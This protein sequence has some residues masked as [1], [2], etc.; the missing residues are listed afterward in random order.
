MTWAN[1]LELRRRLYSLRQKEGD[2]VQENIR[3][4][5]EVLE[6]LAVIGDSVKEAVM[7]IC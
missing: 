5:T 1:K 3:K 2:S 4:M 7:L 6:E